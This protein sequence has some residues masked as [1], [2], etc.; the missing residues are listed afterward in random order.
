VTLDARAFHDALFHLCDTWTFTTHVR[1]YV[2]FLSS[3]FRRVFHALPTTDGTDGDGGDGDG[4]GGGGGLGGRV[5]YG[6]RTPR[7][8][9]AAGAGLGETSL[10]LMRRSRPDYFTFAFVG[11]KD[12]DDGG[13]GG[14]GGGS[15][16]KKT[17]KRAPVRPPWA[18]HCR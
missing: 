3:L 11:D 10:G 8:H 1:E 13:G 17:A 6:I 4:D 14:G 18:H 5:R 16:R 9:D 12:G 2:D 7:T 15:A